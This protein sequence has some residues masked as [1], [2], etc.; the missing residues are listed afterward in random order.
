MENYLKQKSCAPQLIG[1]GKGMQPQLGQSKGFP[2]S[3][4]LELRTE[5][6]DVF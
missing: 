6:L 4:E 5:L 3:I 1:V 2:E